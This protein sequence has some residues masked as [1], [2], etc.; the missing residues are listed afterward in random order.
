[1]CF[2]GLMSVNTNCSVKCLSVGLLQD[3]EKR[4]PLH[5]AAYL[6]D[7]EIIELLILSG[8]CFSK[9]DLCTEAVQFKHNLMNVCHSYSEEHFRRQCSGIGTFRQH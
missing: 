3:N 4:T 1:M 5:A 9:E 8:M 6:G 7:A 2:N